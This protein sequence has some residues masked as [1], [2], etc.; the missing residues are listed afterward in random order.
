MQ[1][2]DE[3]PSRSRCSPTATS[4]TRRSSA[5]SPAPSRPPTPS[6]PAERALAHVFRPDPKP[7]APDRPSVEDKMV[8]FGERDGHQIFL[9]AG[10]PRRSDRLPQRHLHIAS[11]GCRARLSSP[12]F[13]GWKTPSSPGPAT[14]SNTTTSIRASSI[15]PWKRS[16]S[17]VSSPAR[18]TAPQATKKPRGRAVAGLNAAVRAGGG[19]DIVFDRCG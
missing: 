2:G 4:R 8:R 7:R 18:S 11:R 15:Q 12:P 14:P 5:R 10:R 6:D 1:P 19:A 3:P 17:G 16:G 13:P 9:V